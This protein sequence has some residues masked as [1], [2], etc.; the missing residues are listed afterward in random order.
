MCQL[1]VEDIFVYWKFSEQCCSLE[2][3]SQEIQA[4]P[5]QTMVGT[6]DSSQE[7][8][9][10]DSDTCNQVI[11]DLIE[12]L[13]YFEPLDKCQ[14]TTFLWISNRVY[15]NISSSLI[16]NVKNIAN[17]ACIHLGI[18]IV[19]SDLTTDQVLLK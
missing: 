11:V 16:N 15:A 10:T 1:K 2:E 8:V 13:K 7:S 4:L 12:Q 3:C 5:Y 14:F 19:G 9:I 17:Y 6:F 18:L